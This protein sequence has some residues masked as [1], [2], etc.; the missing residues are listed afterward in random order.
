MKVG[1][2]ADLRRRYTPEDLRGFVAVAGGDVAAIETVPEPLI[3]ALFSYLLGVELPGPGTNYLKQELTYLAAIPL[4]STLTARV[5]VTRLRPDKDLCDL[6]T[7]LVDED[8]RLL[9]DG[10]ALVLIKDVT[11]RPVEA[12]A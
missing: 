10:R 7:T 9:V 5:E 1:D 2:A 6:A 3:A 11:G 12:G 8:G 4:G